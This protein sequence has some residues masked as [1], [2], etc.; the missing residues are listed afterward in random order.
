[1][2]CLYPGMHSLSTK[3]G[4]EGGHKSDCKIFSETYT[5]AEYV[6]KDFIKKNTVC[7]VIQRH[8]HTGAYV[9]LSKG[10]GIKKI[11]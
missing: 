6:H 11:S 10:G 4:Q 2:Q 7:T 1:M 5:A 3:N 9:N 8:I